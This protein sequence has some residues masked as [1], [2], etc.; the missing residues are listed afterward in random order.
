MIINM[1]TITTPVILTA[2]RPMI[3]SRH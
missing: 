3:Q 1:T 2:Q